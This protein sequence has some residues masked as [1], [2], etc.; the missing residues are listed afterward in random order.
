MWLSKSDVFLGPFRR[1]KEE[2][3]AVQ[4]ILQRSSEA[5]SSQRMVGAYACYNKV[6]ET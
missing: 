6:I 4:T 1:P 2:G 5:G 3:P